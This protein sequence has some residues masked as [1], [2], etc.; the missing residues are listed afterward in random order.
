MNIFDK[1][2]LPVAT[3]H[4]TTFDLS[5]D[6]VTTN[7]FLT[8]KVV[9]CKEIVPKENITVKCESLTRMSPLLAPTFMRASVKTRAFF[10]PFRDVWRGWNYFITNTSSPALSQISN[11]PTVAN[12]TLV[13]TFRNASNQLLATSGAST[14][15]DINYQGYD[16]STQTSTYTK[17]KFTKKGRMVYDILVGLGYRINW[18]NTDTSNFSLLPILCYFK[19][20]CDW[21]YH[22]QYMV[23]NYA[24]KLRESLAYGTSITQ[25]DLNFIFD[26]IGTV[27]CQY[28]ND[29]FS[30]AFNNANGPSADATN[31]SISNNDTSSND[32]STSPAGN[33]VIVPDMSSGT[34]ISKINQF[35]IDALKSLSDYLKRHQL[36]GS[37][38]V[39]RFASRFGI[40]LSSEQLQK[41]IYLG[42]D[43]VKLQI[44]DVYNQSAGTAS[45]NV[46]LG[47]YAGKGMGYG[48]NGTWTFNSTEFGLFI[49]VT[50]IVPRVGYVQGVKRHTMHMTPL[51]FYTPEFDG[52]GNQA[53]AMKEICLPKDNS[54]IANWLSA[55]RSLDSNSVYG[56][57]PRYA[58]YKFGLD[59]LSG[60]YIYPSTSVGE[61]CWHGFRLFRDGVND[62]LQTDRLYGEHTAGTLMSFATDA[63]QYDRIFADDITTN[64]AGN[65]HFR[66]I[67]HFDVKSTMPMSS[68]FENYHFEEAGK[69][70]IMQL[71]GSSLKN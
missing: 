22:N 6:H 51:D 17:Y 52:L 53:I 44:G 59:Y 43:D 7:N 49:V 13:F 46:P 20:L 37:Q 30:S 60:N 63:N 29:Y 61:D 26:Q 15:P 47:E 55:A 57:T 64:T 40:K 41:S 54:I 32:V 24:D 38:A 65:D 62:S 45:T 33:A 34:A 21:Y 70:Y 42:T 71:G 11:V 35:A 36:A 69:N 14:N 2:K 10:V 67:F 12:N 68:M 23:V 4:K 9:Y 8:P 56:F 18:T 27:S 66:C 58:E 5:C 39:D 19:V 48:N 1:I 28:D 16:S 25:N 31:F 50:N 3:E